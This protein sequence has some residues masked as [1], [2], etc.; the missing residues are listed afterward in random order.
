MFRTVSPTEAP[1]ETTGVDFL[2]DIFGCSVVKVQLV[3][4]FGILLIHR[5][6]FHCVPLPLVFALN[7]LDLSVVSDNRENQIFSSGYIC[8]L[9][10]TAV[11]PH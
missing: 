9:Y 3:L 4:V 5:L 1:V 11:T 2:T 8:N 6:F 7:P 10:I